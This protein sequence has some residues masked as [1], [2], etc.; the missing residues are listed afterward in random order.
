MKIEPTGKTGKIAAQLPVSP[1]TEKAEVKAKTPVPV[2]KADQKPLVT[3]HQ[4]QVKIKNLHHKMQ[5]HLA[6]NPC[7]FGF[8]HQIH[9]LSDPNP[10]GA[11]ESHDGIS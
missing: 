9:Q 8:I 5:H 6:E 3:N 10:A 7:T 1:K 11:A 2:D 4:L